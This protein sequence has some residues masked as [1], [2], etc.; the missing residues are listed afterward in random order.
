MQIPYEA[1]YYSYYVIDFHN[2]TF[3]ICV[4][5]LTFM[6]SDTEDK[7]DDIP[8]T[9]KHQTVIDIDWNQKDPL[10]C[11]LYVSDI[12]ENKRVTEVCLHLYQ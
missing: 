4:E 11:S 5:S 6:V 2:L 1:Y 9:S 12:Y 7:L 10:M 8:G 3:T